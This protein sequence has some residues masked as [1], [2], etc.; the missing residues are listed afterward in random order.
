MKYTET[1]DADY[2]RRQSEKYQKYTRWCI[3][4]IVVFNLITLVFLLLPDKLFK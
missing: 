3:I 1:K 2:Y 4:G